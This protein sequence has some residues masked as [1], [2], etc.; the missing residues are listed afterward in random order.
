M[1]VAIIIVDMLEDFFRTPPL[2]QERASLISSTNEL[3]KAARA[4]SIPV[5]WIRQEFKDDLSDA[6]LS[7]KDSGNKIT[8]SG[9]DGCK[10]LAELE[11]ESLDHE[12]IKKRYSAF[13]STDLD[14]L[15]CQLNCSRVVI[16]GV[17][18]HACVRST[19]VDAYQ[20]DYRVTLALDA[21]S[22]YDKG[23]HE[24]SMRYM[25]QSIGEALTNTQIVERHLTCC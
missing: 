7:M 13:F 8:I 12:V 10:L 2:S 20:R 18:T 21:I 16:A 15:L 4:K 14:K 19:A 22:S 11:V 1:T 3:T 9:T 24:E 23:Y 17:N 5:I 6:Y 25:K